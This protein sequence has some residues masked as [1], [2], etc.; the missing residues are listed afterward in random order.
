MEENDAVE[1]LIAW[2]ERRQSTSRVKLARGFGGKPESHQLRRRVKCFN[3]GKIG[4]FKKDCRA[5][6]KGAG[7]GAASASA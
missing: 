1:A 4:H 6:P 5:P 2:K 3:C 7:R